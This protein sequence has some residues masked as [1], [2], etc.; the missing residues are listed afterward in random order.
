VARAAWA[1]ASGVACSLRRWIS[2]DFEMDQF[3]QNLQ[4]RLQ[5]ERFEIVAHRQIV[6]PGSFL[7]F[8]PSG[9]PGGNIGNTE[10]LTDD[11]SCPVTSDRIVSIEDLE[12]PAEDDSLSAAS[13]EQMHRAATFQPLQERT[14]TG[15][16]PARH[17][18]ENH[19]GQAVGGGR[20]R[21]EPRLVQGS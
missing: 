2:R 20:D 10:W 6:G 16:I 5:P 11:P 4:P 9:K 18:V 12:I 14:A 1:I 13:L 17:V 7:R 19:T 15:K 8:H 3:W 21:W